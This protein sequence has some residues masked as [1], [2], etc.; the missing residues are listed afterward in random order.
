MP[1]QL[2]IYERVLSHEQI[3]EDPVSPPSEVQENQHPTLVKS[4]PEKEG[5]PIEVHISHVENPSLFYIRIAGDMEKKLKEY[6]QHILY[7]YFL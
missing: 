7:I 3:E 1:T 4:F 5:K 2:V 6:V